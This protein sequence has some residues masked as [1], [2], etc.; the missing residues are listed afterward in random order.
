MCRGHDKVTYRI[1]KQAGTGRH[2][3]K[4]EKSGKA[5]IFTLELVLFL[6]MKSDRNSKC[7]D[8]DLS[9]E[10]AELLVRFSANARHN[11]IIPP[12]CGSMI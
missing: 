7:A 3:G 5:S 4:T 6:I 2:F 8:K 11:S 1:L 12:P 9:R 10:S